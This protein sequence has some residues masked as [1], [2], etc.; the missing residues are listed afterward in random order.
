MHG[1]RRYASIAV[2]FFLVL[3]CIVELYLWFRS[4]HIKI[5]N[6]ILLH[7]G[8]PLAYTTRVGGNGQFTTAI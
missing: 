4:M 8:H 1:I 5:P 7:E 3:H 2:V 6:P